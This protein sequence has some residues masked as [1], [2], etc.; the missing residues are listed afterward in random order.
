MK[1]I[2]VVGK[3]TTLFK[4]FISIAKT[5]S[6]PPQTVKYPIKHGMPTKLE[7]Y[8]KNDLHY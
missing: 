6:N 7:P 8:N 1:K 3:N 2:H 4:T 5:T